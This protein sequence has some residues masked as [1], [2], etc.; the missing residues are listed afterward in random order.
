MKTVLI[1]DDEP[2]IRLLMDRILRE[3]GYSTLLAENGEEA[4]AL[5][6]RQPIELI[7]CNMRMPRMSGP[8]LHG[9]LADFCPEL[10]HRMVFC[11]GDIAGPTSHQFLQS[12]EVPWIAK[13]F[14]LGEFLELVEVCAGA[15]ITLGTRAAEAIAAMGNAPDSRQLLATGPT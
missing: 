10:A 6:A 15:P 1:V 11:S 12:V 5:I 9:L 7:I 2:D 13:P 4:L 14:D 8:A 3:R